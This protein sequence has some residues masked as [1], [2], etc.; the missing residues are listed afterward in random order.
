[1]QNFLAI[2][3]ELVKH[4][5][6]QELNDFIALVRLVH[7]D[8][9]NAAKAVELTAKLKADDDALAASVAANQPK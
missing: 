3:W 1:M 5:K 2:F 6:W 9:N 7:E 4:Q 8:E